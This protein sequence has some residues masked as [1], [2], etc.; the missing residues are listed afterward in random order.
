VSSTGCRVP[1]QGRVLVVTGVA[2]EARIAAGFGIVTL[3]SGGSPA[4]L[5]DLLATYDA[6]G[7]SAVV[8]FGIA[9]GLDPALASGDVVAGSEIAFGGAKLPTD[10][11][12]TR[13]LLGALAGRASAGGIAGVDIAMVDAAGKAA[14]YRATGA[15]VVDMESHVAGEFAARH[16]VS[17]AALRVVCD[18]AHHGL[19]PLVN[20]ALKPDGSVSLTGVLGSLMR[21]PGQ[22]PDLIRLA[23][24]SAVAF[25]ALEAAAPA[26]RAS[27]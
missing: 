19:P 7:L 25:R 21:N 10:P 18:P 11:A 14:A 4:R 17:F 12:L 13:S 9:G 20:E 5:R 16:G 27:I 1:G 8:S 3:C 23:R 2:R 6:S 15:A 24:Q 22:I 26:L